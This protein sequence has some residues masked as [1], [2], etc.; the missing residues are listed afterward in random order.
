MTRQ[1]AARFWQTMET[2]SKIGESFI[3]LGPLDDLRHHYDSFQSRPQTVSSG[4]P[5]KENK[6]SG[7]A[8]PTFHDFVMKNLLLKAAFVRLG[9]FSA[10]EETEERRCVQHVLSIYG[11][12]LDVVKSDAGS[13]VCGEVERNRVNSGYV[14]LKCAFDSYEDVVDAIPTE[15]PV[16][17]ADGTR[18]ERW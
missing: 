17:R 10:V 1:A 13:T 16:R 6:A 4:R 9:K 12:L 15:A 5:S 2:T 3:A 18:W 14:I 8:A 7:A 11:D